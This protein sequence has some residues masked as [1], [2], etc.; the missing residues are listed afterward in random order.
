MRTDG[1]RSS[2]GS[3]GVHRIVATWR[4]PDGTVSSS[5]PIEYQAKDG[6]STRFVAT[7][8][9]GSPL[10]SKLSRPPGWP[11]TVTSTA[12]LPIA[13]VGESEKRQ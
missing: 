10:T 3:P 6:L 13:I 7:V 4:G 11:S 2:K 12:Q 8:G 5:A 9:T 1:S